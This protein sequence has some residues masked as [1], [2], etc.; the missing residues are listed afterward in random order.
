MATPRALQR[1]QLRAFS[2]KTP[3][4]LDNLWGRCVVLCGCQKHLPP[5]PVDH[6]VHV[7]ASAR[8][9]L[10]EQ[11]EKAMMAQPGVEVVRQQEKERQACL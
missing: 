9:T 10:G 5:F 8:T 3:S 2:E 7:I 1:L 11:L 4:W 6:Y